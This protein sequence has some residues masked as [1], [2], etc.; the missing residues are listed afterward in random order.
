MKIILSR[1]GFDSEFGGYPSPILPDGRLISLPIPSN[2]QEHYSN[3][4]VD[5]NRTYY[6]LMKQ[7]GYSEIRLKANREKLT[8]KTTCHRDPDIYEQ[9]IPRQPDWRGCFGQSR[10]SQSHLCKEITKNDLFLFFG[11][12]KETK[13][14]NGQLEFIPNTDKHVIFGYLEVCEIKPIS[15]IADDWKREHEWIMFHPHVLK[16]NSDNDALYIASQRLSWNQN[17][18]GSGTFKTDCSSESP[19]VLTKKGYSKSKWSLPDFFRETKIS[20]HTKDSWKDDYFQST[21]RGQ[22]FVIQGT[23]KIENWARSLINKSV[24]Q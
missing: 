8:E 4:M 11:W 19:L 21:A 17:L 6:D 15:Q 18:S 20:W 7:I 1:K 2:D 10:Q 22:A 23:E 13:E 3:L 16:P 24:K 14:R 12:F 5:N 9:I